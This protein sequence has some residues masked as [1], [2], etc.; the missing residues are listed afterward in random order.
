M[1][2]LIGRQEM[3]NNALLNMSPNEDKLGQP[4]KVGKEEIVGLLKTLD[5]YLAEDEQSLTKEQ[6]RQL[7]T[8]ANGRRMELGDI[9]GAAHCQCQ[10][11]LFGQRSRMGT[12][13]IV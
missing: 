4:T 9:L 13:Q 10:L 3:I 8:I 11:F 12:S 6:W 1:G 7:D 2:L 5:L